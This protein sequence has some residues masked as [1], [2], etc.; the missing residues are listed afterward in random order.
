MMRLQRRHQGLVRGTP[1]GNMIERFRTEAA[2]N[3]PH[4]NIITPFDFGEFDRQPDG[5]TLAAGEG[6]TIKLW[7]VIGAAK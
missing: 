2:T 3:I 1:T 6:K 5:R 4:K 7:A